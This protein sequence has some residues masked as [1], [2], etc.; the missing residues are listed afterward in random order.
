MVILPLLL[1]P[2]FF[3][4]ASKELT[5]AITAIGVRDDRVHSVTAPIPDRKL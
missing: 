5:R 2:P 4:R 1:S 3:H